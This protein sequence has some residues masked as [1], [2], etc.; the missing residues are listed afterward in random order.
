M[1][2]QQH[3]THYPAMAVQYGECARVAHTALWPA[4]HGLY[5]VTINGKRVG[6]P[7][8]FDDAHTLFAR[9]NGAL[10]DTTF[11]EATREGYAARL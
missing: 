11:Q 10:R 4:E 2:G 7:A 1:R 3:A 6:E 5:C 8:P 9:I